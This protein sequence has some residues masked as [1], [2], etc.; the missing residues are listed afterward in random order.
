LDS[1]HKVIC[2][3]DLFLGT[4]DGAAVYPREVAVRALQY[5]AGA[6]IFAHNHPSGVASP[7]NADK[8]ITER[9]KN[10]LSLLDIRVLDH[11]IIGRGISFSFA[12]AGLL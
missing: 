9:L 6:V 5:R 7:S 12:E 4:L 3:E 11:V 2:C 8:R 10:A 1:Q